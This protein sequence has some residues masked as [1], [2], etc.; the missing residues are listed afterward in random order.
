MHLSV[1]EWVAGSFVMQGVVLFC[2]KFIFFNKSC[3]LNQIFSHILK[4]LRTNLSEIYTSYFILFS[5]CICYVSPFPLL[6]FPF[7]FHLFKT[8]FAPIL[9]MNLAQG[10]LPAFILK[11][12]MSLVT[13]QPMIKKRNVWEDKILILSIQAWTQPEITCRQW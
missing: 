12:T 7:I 9:S 2:L 4:H 8:L 10:G 1:S 6:S 11:I 5:L 3:F 13:I